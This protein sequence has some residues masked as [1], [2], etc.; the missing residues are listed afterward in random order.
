MES[1]IGLLILSS[2]GPASLE[3]FTTSCREMWFKTSLE[4]LEICPHNSPKDG[5]L[6]RN[7]FRR[8]GKKQKKVWERPTKGLKEKV[9]LLALTKEKEF[10]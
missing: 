2:K 6:G 3:K 10:L 7:P 5:G 1:I 9:D 8:I 4:R